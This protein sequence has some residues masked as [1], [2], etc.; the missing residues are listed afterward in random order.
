MKSPPCGHFLVYAFEDYGF[1]VEA[2][3]EVSS[4]GGWRG[5]DMLPPEQCIYVSHNCFYLPTVLVLLLIWYCLYCLSD[6]H[7]TLAS[8]STLIITS[9]LQHASVMEQRGFPEVPVRPLAYPSSPNRGGTTDMGSHPTAR[10]R[11]WTKP[12]GCENSPGRGQVGEE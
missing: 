12:Q 1:R 8:R 7:R 10:H 5:K 3:T 11:R 4:R 2:T 9:S 6:G